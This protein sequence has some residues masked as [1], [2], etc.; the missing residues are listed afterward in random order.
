MNFDTAQYK[1]DLNDKARYQDA[2][3]RLEQSIKLASHE[4]A[5]QLSKLRTPEKVC[6]LEIVNLRAA[7]FDM[8]ALN[9]NG[10]YECIL[11]AFHARWTHAKKHWPPFAEKYNMRNYPLK[12]KAA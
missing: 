5:I 1:K 6:Q 10:E 11:L 2:V 3:N 7:G 8:D 4:D 9:S 12:G